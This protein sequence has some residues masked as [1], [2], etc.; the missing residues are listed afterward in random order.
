MTRRRWLGALAALGLLVAGCGESAKREPQQLAL[1]PSATPSATPDR[2]LP[3]TDAERRVIRGWADELRH[4]DVRAAARYFSVPS[5]VVNL[6]PQ[7]LELNSA[8]RVVDF[9]DSLP[10]GAEVVRIIRTVSHL[11][12]GEFELTDRPGG[13]CGSAAGTRA[14]FAFLIDADDHI[15]RLI[16]IDAGSLPAP[17]TTL[18]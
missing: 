11:V 1:K 7:P 10:C 5:E 12:V 3:V 9:N 14:R 15:E 4:G 16:L 18:A 6:Q 17:D 2:R 8:R 13:D